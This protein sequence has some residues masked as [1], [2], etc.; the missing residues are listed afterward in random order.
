MTA[1]FDFEVHTPY[2]LFFSGKI[3]SV[4]FS[5]ADGEICVMANHSPFAA[6]VVECILRIKDEEGLWKAAFVSRGII[7]VNRKKNV[8]I[9]EAAE[10]PD[11]IDREHAIA[12]KEQAQRILNDTQFKFEL[13]KAKEQL[14]RADYRLKLLAMNENSI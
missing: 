8:L 4:I 14:R 1:L 3:Q 6:P 13:D 10:W 11:E 2:R 12:S 9:V 7:E 5:I